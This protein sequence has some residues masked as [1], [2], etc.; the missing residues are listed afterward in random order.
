MTRVNL[1][2]WTEE[3]VEH[4]STA[5]LAVAAD[6]RNVSVPGALVAFN[7]ATAQALGGDV[8]TVEWDV[9]LI[10]TDAGTAGAL[11]QLQKLANQ[12]EEVTQGDTYTAVMVTLPNHSPDGLPALRTTITTECED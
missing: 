7:N 1:A 12:L 5:G 2:Q 4:L 11:R 8:W 6:K 3:V 10:A 9:L